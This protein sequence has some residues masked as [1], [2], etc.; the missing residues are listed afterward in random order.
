MG[1]KNVGEI[2]NNIL[3]IDNLVEEQGTRVC[4][5]ILYLF[6][7]FFFKLKDSYNKI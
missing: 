1:L 5:M 3:N 7:I 2:E 4:E 6:K